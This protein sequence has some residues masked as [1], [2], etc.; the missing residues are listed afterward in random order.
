MILYKTIA[1][2]VG[3]SLQKREFV[4]MAGPDGRTISADEVRA[5]WQT[6]FS[7]ISEASIYLLDHNAANKAYPLRSGGTG[8]CATGLANL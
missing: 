5:H 3:R 8:C 4:D 7:D 6:V 1:L 2:H